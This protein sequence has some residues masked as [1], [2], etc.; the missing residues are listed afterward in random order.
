MITNYLKYKVNDIDQEFKKFFP[1]FT[2]VLRDFSGGFK[3]LDPSSFLERSLE[4]E[5]G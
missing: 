1:E 4:Q 2:W 3:H 5:R